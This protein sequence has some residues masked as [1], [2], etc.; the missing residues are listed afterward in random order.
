MGL[1]NAQRAA[2]MTIELVAAERR[3]AAALACHTRYDRF[4]DWP[5]CECHYDWDATLDRCAS[6]TVTALTADIEAQ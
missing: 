4:P 1:S 5:L 2:E 6:P 3:I